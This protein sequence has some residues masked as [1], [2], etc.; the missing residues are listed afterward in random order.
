MNS[1]LPSLLPLVLLFSGSHANAAGEPSWRIERGDV[2]IVVPLRPGG[3]FTATT[4][5]LS[6]TLALLP[7]TPAQLTG[8]L[9]MDLAT[10]ETGINLRNQH[11]RDK[12]LE[13]SRGKGFDK[14][15]LTDI[16]LDDATGPAF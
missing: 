6:G 11:L 7:G 5:S 16:K 1:L 2:Q 9:S 4:P 14:A 10:I 12:Y 13:V 15:V 3:A 8:D